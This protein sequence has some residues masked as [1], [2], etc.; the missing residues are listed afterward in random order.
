M[1]L[2][3]CRVGKSGQPA[4]ICLPSATDGAL[5]HGGEEKLEWL[6]QA[7][8]LASHGAP[9]VT[10]LNTKALKITWS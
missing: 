10:L 7:L 4:T 9:C 5:Q 1:G 2:G 6:R 8:D 3:L